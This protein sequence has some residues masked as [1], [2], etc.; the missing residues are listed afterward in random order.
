MIGGLPRFQDG[1]LP[2]TIHDKCDFA[3]EEGK[4]LLLERRSVANHK[5]PASLVTIFQNA[6]GCEELS[7]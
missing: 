1:M 6:V 3:F 7:F 4:I 5:T 2:E